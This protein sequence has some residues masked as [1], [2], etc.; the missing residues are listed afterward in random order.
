MNTNK[1]AI[2]ALA[3]TVVC[4]TIAASTYLK[5][6]VYSL[7]MEL[8]SINKSIQ[9]DKEDI[10]VLKAEWSKLNNPSRLRNLAA[11]HTNLN[12]IK[13]EQI[14]NYSELPFNYE[15]DDKRIVARKN[16]AVAAQNNRDLRKM[17]NNV[18]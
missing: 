13:G 4:F 11:S 6:T 16:I 15:S 1:I 12:S 8:K 17:A 18:R 9:N 10:H 5:N 14:I 2:Y 7:E 3:F